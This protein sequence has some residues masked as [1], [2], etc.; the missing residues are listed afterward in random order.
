MGVGTSHGPERAGLS[1][2]VRSGFQRP[3]FQRLRI[4]ADTARAG[5]WTIHVPASTLSGPGPDAK[6]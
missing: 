6:T 5:G 4:P 2:L 3:G 1:P